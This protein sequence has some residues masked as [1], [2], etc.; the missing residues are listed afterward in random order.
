MF[1]FGFGEMVLTAVVALLVL[2]PKR[3]PLAA[4]TLGLWARRARASWFSLRA[5]LERELADEDIKASLRGAR[6]EMQ[7][8][9]R[10]L[11]A[12]LVPI[13]EQH[14][15]MSVGT[16]AVAVGSSSANE[17]G[18]V[19]SPTTNVKCDPSP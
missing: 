12:P 13:Q 10:E 6:E 14:P 11:E 7:Q 5:E 4:R 1:E 19:E 9:R 15:P 18:H 17:P 2:G 8:L 3:L 16:P